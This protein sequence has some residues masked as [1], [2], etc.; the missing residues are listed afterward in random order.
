MTAHSTDFATWSPGA[1]ISLPQTNSGFGRDL[2]VAYRHLGTGDVVHITQ[3]YLDADG[4]SGFGRYHIRAT[5]DLPAF[6]LEPPADSL[7]G[8]VHTPREVSPRRS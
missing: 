2:D 4:G 1:L 5:P 8:L 7:D 6:L 3:G